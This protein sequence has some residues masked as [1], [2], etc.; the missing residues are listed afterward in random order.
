MRQLPRQCRLCCSLTR[1]RSSVDCRAARRH[2]RGGHLA[3]EAKEH[4]YPPRLPARRPALHARAQSPAQR[5]C[6]KPATRAVIRLGTLYARGRRMP[7]CPRSHRADAAS[8]TDSRFAHPFA[9]VA[10]CW[11]CQCSA[12]SLRRQIQ[13]WSWRRMWS[14]KR[15]NA[16]P[17]AGLP[18]R[19][20]CRATVIIFGVCSPSR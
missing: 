15:A 16:A 19:R 5:S 7:R 18:A 10:E 14:T 11:R 8:T 12:I 3:A 1:S 6:A 17:R 13:T 20:Q 2:P 9:P 4:A